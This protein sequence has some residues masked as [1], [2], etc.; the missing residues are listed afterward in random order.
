MRSLNLDQLRALEAVVALASFTGAARQL[1][2]SQSAVSVQIRELEDRLGVRLVERLG[3]KAYA[4]AAGRDVIEHARRISAETDA[5]E[6]AMRRQRDGWLGRVH[7]A[8]TLTALMYL[9]PPVLKRLHTSHPGI[10]VLV[11]NSSTAGMMDGVLRNEID[12]AL[13]TMPIEDKR[14]AIT[15]LRVEPMVAILPAAARGVP[16]E[17]TPDYVERQFLVLETGAVSER[18]TEWLSADRPRT[19]QSSTRV[20]EVEAVKVVVGAGLGMAIVPGSS[21]E[22]PS[23]DI[24]VR[25]LNPPLIR[26]LAL[27]HHRNK[28]EDPAFRIVRDAMMELSN[29]PARKQRTKAQA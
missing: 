24:V 23:D 1:N 21:M 3:K 7:I 4:T 22:R 9:L 26:R 25:P 2:L 13:V 11:T 17:I 8:G 28:P 18:V 27:I 19:P 29:I 14:L 15:P 5:L 6:T 16:K 12:I 10:D 20:S